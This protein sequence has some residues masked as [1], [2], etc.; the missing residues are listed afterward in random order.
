MKRTKSILLIVTLFI[1][2]TIGIVIAKKNNSVS[3]NNPI[4]SI[5]IQ[6]SSVTASC[7]NKSDTIPLNWKKYTSN[8]LGIS[9]R[10]PDTWNKYGD[11]SNSINRSGAVMSISVN[12]IDTLSHSAFF[13]EYHLAPYGA[14]LFK[15]EKAQ[16]DSSQGSYKNGGKEIMVAGNKAIE[17]FSI[18]SSDI[19]G[20]TYDPPLSI[21]QIVFLDRLQKG[22]FHLR[23]KTPSLPNSEAEI[24]KFNKLLSTI[25]F[26][27]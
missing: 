25:K 23:F 13:I 4:Q 20:N 18:M 5:H 2:V 12:F 15:N 21:I 24:A 9:F 17:S 27:N 26:R 14:E 7:A 10:Y 8:R 1:F 11:E 16:F 22:E 3:Q 6:Q 19:K